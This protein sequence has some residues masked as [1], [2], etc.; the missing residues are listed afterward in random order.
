MQSFIGKR[1]LFCNQEVQVTD[2]V[3]ICPDCGGVYHRTCWEKSGGCLT[4]GCSEHTVLPTKEILQA[5]QVFQ[6]DVPK[7]K[8][9]PNATSPLFC[10]KC[11]T[12]I[13]NGQAFCSGCGQSTAHLFN[14]DTEMLNDTT[15][16]FC[17]RCGSLVD[18]K[19]RFCSNCGQN[20]TNVVNSESAPASISKTPSPSFCEKCGAPTIA[21]EAFCSCC[22]HP[23][24]SPSN[25]SSPVS[26]GSVSPVSVCPQCGQTISP[27]NTFCQKCGLPVNM[28]FTPP[29]IQPTGKKKSNA[30]VIVVTIVIAVVTILLVAGGVF[31]AFLIQGN[32]KE[33]AIQEY[34]DNAES[35]QAEIL[36]AGI[37]L[38][39][40]GNEVQNN[41]YSYLYESY[42]GYDTSNDAVNAAYEAM[43][44]EVSEVELSNSYI[45]DLYDS[46]RT[47]P[48][49]NDT[50]LTE[51]RDAAEDLYYTYYTLYDSVLN[52][53]GSSYISFSSDF[54]DADTKI[55]DD[56]NLFDQLLDSYTID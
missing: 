24:T 13:K 30:T 9:V 38:E 20:I 45:D 39:S 26:T 31:A 36:D 54:L 41:W 51:L 7:E 53:D 8:T 19:D 50:A 15:P 12:P 10:E 1:C 18:S 25:L 4:P 47:V 6:N 5:E 3:Y 43:S 16:V 33:S 49:E 35:F 21:G 23:T 55:V 44:S 34:L 14:T 22:G 28:P 56:Y 37:N 2:G 48:D 46:L 52:P 17:P 32:L 27:G 29:P 11:G 40:I 42:S